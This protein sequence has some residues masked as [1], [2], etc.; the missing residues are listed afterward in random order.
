MLFKDLGFFGL[1]RV[2]DFVC[3]LYIDIIK[4]WYK[5]IEGGLV[6]K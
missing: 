5:L 1:G 6:Y 2:G 4:F 3:L